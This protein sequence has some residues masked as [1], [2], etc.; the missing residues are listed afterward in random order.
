[1]LISPS[2]VEE[3]IERNEKLNIITVDSKD[4]QLA[5]VLYLL[6]NIEQKPK[7][8]PNK[9]WMAIKKVNKDFVDIIAMFCFNSVFF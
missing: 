9:I 4:I 2:T 3:L 7:S 6:F 5:K 8:K 1:M